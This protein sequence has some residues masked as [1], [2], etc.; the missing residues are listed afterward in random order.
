MRMC[1]M[2]LRLVAAVFIVGAFAND[3]LALSQWSRK[4]NVSCSQCHSAFPRLNAYGDAFAQNGYQVPGSEDGD[5]DG[6][7]KIED[8]LNLNSLVDVFGI[9]VSY[10]P[11][12]YK[13]NSRKEADGSLDDTVDEGNADWV[14]LFVGGSIAKNISTF[15]ETEI[16]S[17]SVHINW[18]HIGFNNL[19]GMGSYA[20]I[21]AGRLS[22]FNWHAMT[23]RL[24]AIAP[25]K[26]QVFDYKSSN[27]K[28]DD[29]VAVASPY[30]AVEYYGYNKYLL[31][32]V[33]VQN[34]G[35]ATD[36][37]DSKNL[38]ATL[39]AWLAQK[40]NFE[41]SAISVGG[42]A[43]TD[44]KL[45]SATTNATTLAVTPA[46]EAENEFWRGGPA[47][48][49]RFRDTTDFQAAYFVGSDDN[50]TLASPT[51]TKTEVDFQGASA[52]LGHWL[53]HK[54]WAALQY[55]WIDSDDDA[56]DYDK[57]TAAISFSPRE[58]IRIYLVGRADLRDVDEK[59]NEAFVNI[60]AMF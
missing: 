39:K 1:R 47:L 31:W 10:T 29:S 2:G 38:Y 19:F 42:L 5:T 24:R 48:N 30:P 58:N 13:S 52:L 27:G 25:V 36:V 49:I 3:S 18:F 16:T 56:S 44:T 7:I 20:N 17:D 59:V 26:N 46:T 43:G 53:S 21:R 50:W 45:L 9:R 12:S 35:K 51:S 6:K 41:G 57:G 37:N 15:I 32:A 54:W 34:G 8:T 40:G 33:G 11:I 23:G 60:R 22:A 4:Y 14:Q 55:D 28:G